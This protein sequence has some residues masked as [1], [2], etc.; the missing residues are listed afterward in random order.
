MVRMKKKVT[1]FPQRSSRRSKA[2][3]EEP[4]VI[5]SLGG[6][7]LA[8]HYILTELPDKAAEVISIEKSPQRK[9]TKPKRRSK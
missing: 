1:P 6:R 9:V 7:R 8:L 2:P 5:F 4:C 3:I